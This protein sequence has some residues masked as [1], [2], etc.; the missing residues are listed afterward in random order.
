MGNVDKKLHLYHSVLLTGTVGILKNVSKEPAAMLVMLIHVDPMPSASRVPMIPPVL[1][2]LDIQ[3]TQEFSAQ[4]FLQP[5]W[6]HQSPNAEI[7][8]NAPTTIPAST[9]NALILA[10]S[11][12]HALPMLTAEYKTT[13]Q[14]VLVLQG[15]SEI[16]EYPA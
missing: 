10:P 12:I 14:C 4:R 7:T 3:E 1:A 5:L 6:I 2:Q 16:Q 11:L 9:D 13:N 15:T 8:A